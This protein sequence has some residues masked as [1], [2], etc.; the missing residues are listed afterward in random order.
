MKNISK[1]NA[2]VAIAALGLAIMATPATAQAVTAPAADAPAAASA[3]EQIIVTGTSIRRVNLETPSPIQ[4]ISSKELAL[5]GNDTIAGVLN[6]VSANG[7]GTLSANNSNAFAGG[8]SG[9]SLRG[10]SV[11]DT[12]TLVDGHRLAPYP[13]SDDGQRQFTDV[14]SIPFNAIESVDILK[15]GASAIY[16][17]DAIAGVVNVHLKKQITGIEMMMEEGL[18]QHGGGNTQHYGLSYGKGDIAR[19]GYNAF[20]TIEFRKQEEITLNQ[21]QY[22]PWAS[23][24]FASVGGNNIG[25]G[26]PNAINAFLPATTVPYLVNPNVSNPQSTQG[27]L[28]F[29]GAGCNQTL[30]AGGQCGSI[31]RQ[32]LQAPT[33]NINVLA[34]FTK[35]FGGGWQAKFRASFFDSKG[36]QSNNSPYS[37]FGNVYP[38]ASYGGNTSNAIGG[39]PVTGVGSGGVGINGAYTVPAN[40]AGNPFGV[41]AYLEGFLPQLNAPT[42]NIDSQTIRLALDI[43][44]KAAGWDVTA[45]LGMS[46]VRTHTE[47]LNFVNFDTLYTDLNNLN[48]AGQPAFNP[49]GGNSAAELARIAPAFEAVATDALYYAEFT[50]TRKIVDLPGGDLRLAVGVSFVDKNLNNPGAVPVLDGQIGGAFSA[51]AIGKQS[52][53]AG[54]AELDATLFHTVDINLAGRDDYYNTYGNSFTPKAGITWR[55]VS[56]VL[57]RGTFSK[58][59]RAPSPAEVGTAGSLFGLGSF[60]DPLLCPNGSGGPFPAGTVPSSCASNPGY[61]QRTNALQPEKST[62]FTGG[63]VITPFSGFSFTAD[64]YHIKISN[65]IVSAA[66]LPSYAASLGQLNGPCLRGPATATN[67]STGLLNPDGSPQTTS[68]TP[69]YGPIAACIAGYVNAQSTSTSGIDLEARYRFAVGAAKFSLSVN[70]THLLTYN[71]TAPSGAVYALAGTHGPS[72]VSG[73]TGNPRDHINASVGMDYGNFS[74]MI[75][76]YRIGSY[77]IVDPSAGLTSCAGALGSAFMFITQTTG[78]AQQSYCKVKAFTSVNLALQYRVTPKF[79]WKLSVENLFDASAPVDAQTYGGGFTPFNPSLHEDGV[80]GRFFRLGVDAKF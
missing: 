25:P 52:D 54:Y 50:G 14:A 62:S 44:G 15:D 1:L 5:S 41:P 48:A 65:Q 53:T 24:N 72:G 3:P 29:L 74:G 40:F 35:A 28:A 66:E 42:I 56:S 73:D 22:E 20:I 67:I 46:H 23:D 55:P 30:L 36:Q 57:L 34:G 77:S 63:A 69:L 75:S 39:L 80:I 18:S 68:G 16:G 26:Q 45:S 31:N 37:G 51:F 6:S 59:F 38:G 61:A 58:G 8:A 21:R 76:G 10:L 7:A 17:S 71:L 13:L 32:V 49:L 60:P 12:L 4:I 19:D 43:T 11:G 33:Q 70:Y 27:A 78:P 47:Y 64:Y 79:T 9:I 2:G